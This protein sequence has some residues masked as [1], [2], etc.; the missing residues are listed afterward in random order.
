LNDG[1]GLP[2]PSDD[3]Q[4]RRGAYATLLCEHQHGDPDMRMTA[5]LLALPAAVLAACATTPAFVSSWRAPDAQPLEVRGSK[6]AAVVML[7]SEAAR[8][9]AEEKL[10][11]EITARGARGIPM[12]TIYPDSDPSKEA[13]A[14]AALDAAGVLGV[15]VMRPLRVDKEVVSTPVTYTEPV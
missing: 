13:Q 5:L 9:V 14:R 11:A 12:Y 10:A 1:I 6:G 2:I 4:Q 3:G 8:R 7:D 15:V